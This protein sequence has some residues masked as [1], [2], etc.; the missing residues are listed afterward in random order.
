MSLHQTLTLL[1]K[2]DGSIDSIFSPSCCC[3]PETALWLD[4]DTQRENDGGNIKR[5]RV[6][7]NN[8]HSF[9]PSFSPA[10]PP[11]LPAHPPSH[12]NSLD[13]IHAMSSMHMLQWHQMPSINGSAP[14]CFLV[15]GAY[16]SPGSYLWAL[17]FFYT[18]EKEGKKERES[19]G[20][21][22]IGAVVLC[23]LQQQGQYR[24]IY[25]IQPS[26]WP[27]CRQTIRAHWD[28]RMRITSTGSRVLRFIKKDLKKGGGMGGKEKR[29]SRGGLTVTEI[30]ADMKAK[31]SGF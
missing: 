22:S 1:S 16:S 24:L 23:E 11:F 5:K 15:M 2:A 10:L 19:S 13:M 14:P 27:F 31:G 28:C 17:S 8:R 20:G 9:L 30:W 18:R 26:P 4:L 3:D 12:L 6:V 7:Y 25:P 29:R 21:N